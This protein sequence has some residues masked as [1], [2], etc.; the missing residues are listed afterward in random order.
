MA[1]AGV[2]SRHR[3]TRTGLHLTPLGRKVRVRLGGPERG[4]D[5]PILVQQGV[6][7][8]TAFAVLTSAFVDSVRG[9]GAR[10]DYRQYLKT[11]SLGSTS[12]VDAA[13]WI[14]QYLS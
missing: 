4:Y 9:S 7:D 6:F 3:R 10:V 8:P 14:D 12:Q 5:A 13:A 1:D 2:Q 11:H